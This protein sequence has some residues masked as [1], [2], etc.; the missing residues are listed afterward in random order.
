MNKWSQ[1]VSWS[2]VWV[3]YVYSS[4][5]YERY[6]VNTGPYHLTA[7]RFFPERFF[8]CPMSMSIEWM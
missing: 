7:T 6:F 8:W 3:I 5:K 4:V 1:V 2:H